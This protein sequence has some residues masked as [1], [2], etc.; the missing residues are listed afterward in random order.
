MNDLFE[1]IAAMLAAFGLWKLLHCL[2]EWIAFPRAL[3][4][5]IYPAVFIDNDTDDLTQ[6]A[7]YVKTLSREG[8]ISHGRLIIIAKSGIIKNMPGARV[9]TL[10]DEEHC[11]E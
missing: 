5:R 6:I 9:I 2:F 4:K 10:T 3:R 11:S 7:A 8:K 1:I